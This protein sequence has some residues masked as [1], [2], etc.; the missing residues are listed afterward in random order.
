[1]NHELLC[2]CITWLLLHGNNYGLLFIGFIHINMLSS[3]TL[4]VVT[5]LLY[6]Q[7]VIGNVYVI[8]FLSLYVCIRDE[9]LYGV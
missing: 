8:A 3:T 2:V 9:T 1:M 7:D 6:R 5:L 4:V